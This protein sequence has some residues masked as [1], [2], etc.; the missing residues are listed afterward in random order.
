MKIKSIICLIVAILLTVSSFVLSAPIA[1]ALT[2]EPVPPRKDVLPSEYCLRDDY[3]VYA[4]N[5]DKHGYCWNFASVM[6]VSTTIMKATGEYYDFS[7]L[8]TGVSLSVATNKYSK[9]GGGGTFKYHYESFKT[10]GLMLESDMPYNYSYTMSNENVVDYYNFYE[11]YSNDDLADCIVYD[12]STSYSTD[13]VE[14]IKEHIY[15]HGSLYIAFTF[16]D[17][18]VESDGTYY[19]PP[20][21]TNTDG[22]HAVSLIGWD[23]NY[24]RTVYVDGSDTP[25]VFRGAW[26]ILNSYTETSGIDGIS[27]VFYDD[28]NLYEV[29]GYKYEPDTSKDLYFYDKI[30]EGYSCPNYVK[31]KY[32]GDLVAEEGITKQKNIFYD[33]VDL[34]YSYIISEGA[35]VESVSIYLDKQNVTEKFSVHIDNDAKRFYISGT[36]AAYGQYKVLVKYGDGNKSDTYL[37]NF[38]VTYGLV[39]EEIEFD[40]AQTDFAFNPGRDLEFYS[41]ISSDKNYVIYTN[42]LSGSVSFVPTA[43]SVYSEHSMSLPGISYEITN[44]KDTVSTYSI[45]SNSGYSLDY[46]FTFEYYE[47]TS[48]QP[49]RVYYDLGGGVN[50]SKN[51]SCELA[52]ST[53]DLLL[54]EPTRP[55]YTFAGWYLD[56]GSGSKKVSEEAGVYYISWD[57]IHHMGEAPTMF[58]SSY[59]KKYYKNSNTVFVY[60]LWEN[61]YF[62]VDLTVIGEGKAQID[63]DIYVNSSDSV[64]YIFE[65]EAGYCLSDVKVNGESLPFDELVSVIKY[66]LVIKDIEEDISITATFSEGVYLSIKYGENIKSAYI[67]A[68][69]NGKTEKFYNGDLIP[70][71]YFG[72]IN[73][74]EPIVQDRSDILDIQAKAPIEN[75]LSGLVS[76]LFGTTFTLVVELEDARD[77]Y[78]YVLD[79]YD[80]YTVI[81]DGVFKKS[82][83]IKRTEQVREINVGSAVER[84]SEKVN[85]TYTTRYYIVDHYLS[86]DKNAKNGNKNSGSYYSGEV[87]YLFIQKYPDSTAHFYYLPEEFEHVRDDW[88]RLAIYV[89]ALNPDLGVFDACQE[90]Q[91]YDITWKNWDGT[92]IYSEQ[93]YFNEIPVFYNKKAEIKDKPI[94]PDDEF[95]TYTFIGWNYKIGKAISDAEYTAVYQAIPKRFTVTVT[96]AENGKIIGNDSGYISYTDSYTYVFI[97]DEGYCVKDVIVNGESVGAVSFYTFTETMCDQTLEVVFQQA[98]FTV[99]TSASEH[100]TVTPT[101]SS[102][103]GKSYSVV[104]TPDSW[105]K[106]KEVIIDGVSVGVVDTYTF[107]DVDSDHSVQVYY[108]LDKTVLIII[109]IASVA[110]IGL[111]SVTVV[112]V[113]MQR[114]H[115][116][117]IIRARL[118][119]WNLLPSGKQ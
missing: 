39:G 42:K 89:D 30:E 69:Y 118:K 56:Y 24:E 36:D 16:R 97:P 9:I 100:G 21:Q 2:I 12:G 114:K 6:A 50:H 8:W 22:N 3:V 98:T 58:A 7:E 80:D 40:Y 68:K 60:A 94:R 112:A 10:S 93:Y 29:K 66:G 5:Q 101:F 105:Y 17:G 34:Q 44:G 14:A 33:D 32:Y 84:P 72:T 41:F 59:Y 78:T 76:P 35:S 28:N 115:R 81:G 102:S 47:D 109:C 71:I 49:V 1:N 26:L 70:S 20:N 96:P 87:I 91:M 65:P 46:N 106:V 116:K 45:M 92:V 19:L 113:R 48:L 75:T 74:L 37:N 103:R 15:N 54:Y 43:Q 38:Y 82:I 95:Y 108:E 63:G 25:T 52:N 79:N 55:G 90:D 86:N 83:S 111:V 88:Y 31:G 57:D 11:K 119:F 62:N 104:F 107:F 23:D 51:Y 53:T 61:E 117:Q 64:R 110:L 99:H 73:K 67:V 18:F 4:Q 85:V 27:H 13:D 77:G